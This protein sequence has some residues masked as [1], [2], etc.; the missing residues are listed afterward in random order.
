ML[1]PNEKSCLDLCTSYTTS[2]CRCWQGSADITGLSFPGKLRKRLLLEA[3][4]HCDCQSWKCFGVKAGFPRNAPTVIRRKLA[5]QESKSAALQAGPGG[6]EAGAHREG[7]K[8][9]FSFQ[10][11]GKGLL[12]IWL[13]FI[14][15]GRLSEGL[16]LNMADND[17]L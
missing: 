14:L 16:I 2:I 17:L 12:E 6:T 3:L 10:R 5:S 4:V 15:K 1:G 8:H 9:R 7:G 11:Q 13:K